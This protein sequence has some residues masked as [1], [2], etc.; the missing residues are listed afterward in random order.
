MNEIIDISH[1]SEKSAR[2]RIANKIIAAKASPGQFVII[3]FSA[4][5]QRIP[6]SIVSTEP[7]NGIID[8][9]MHRAD[10]LDVILG[11]IKVGDV[12]PDLLGPLGTPAQIE[13]DKTILFIGD[14]VGF[15]PLLPLIK[16]SRNNGCKVLALVSEQSSQTQCLVGDINAECDT[17]T[18]ADE[19]SVLMMY[20]QW[21]EMFKPSKIIM[22]G[23]TQLMKDL[24]TI[25]REQN[26]PADCVLNMLMIDGIGICGVCRVIVGNKKKQTCIDGPVFNAWEV[27][28]DDMMNRQRSF[29]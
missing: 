9:I 29:V 28:F 10:G 12:L 11:L 6:F 2:V 8:I 27:D 14:G 4:D 22:A 1:Y 17:L 5:G 24:T 20:R 23:P 26:V 16:A 15:V 19:K 3:K 7:E 21:I 18:V 13:K 25:A